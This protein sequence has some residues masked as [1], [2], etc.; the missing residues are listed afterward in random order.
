MT[1]Q[2]RA[3]DDL[4][5]TREMYDDCTA[6][7][8]ALHLPPLPSRAEL[9]AELAVRPAPRLRYDEHHETP[10]PQITV[11]EAARRLA[12]VFDRD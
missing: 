2:R 10:K 11:T 7:G 9:L 6:A 8:S 5:S 12:V 4:S 1:Y 3:Y